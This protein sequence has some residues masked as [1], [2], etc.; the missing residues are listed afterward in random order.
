MQ[1]RQIRKQS[2]LCSAFART[3]VA[4]KEQVLLRETDMIES[5]TML[6]G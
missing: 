2:E 5:N 6:C 3:D 1:E 4:E